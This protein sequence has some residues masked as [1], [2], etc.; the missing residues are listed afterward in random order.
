[1]DKAAV[2]VVFA[3]AVCWGCAHFVNL[4]VISFYVAG[5]GITRTMLV[6]AL[7]MGLC[8]KLINK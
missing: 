5:I 4:N 3:L 1:M 6:A 2:V 7:G 8:Y